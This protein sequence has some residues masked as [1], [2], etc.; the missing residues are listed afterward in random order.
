[1]EP[2]E[3]VLEADGVILV[4]I[5]AVLFAVFFAVFF[6]VLFGMTMSPSLFASGS[7]FGAFSFGVLLSLSVAGGEALVVVSLSVGAADGAVQL[8]A[9]IASSLGVCLGL[10]GVVDGSSVSTEAG[11]VAFELT[12]VVV[13]ITGLGVNP[14]GD[15]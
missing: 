11:L 8:G 5:L 9:L 6:A 7:L 10:G 13:V 2:L 12:L 4:L 1:M 14:E 3:G 15:L